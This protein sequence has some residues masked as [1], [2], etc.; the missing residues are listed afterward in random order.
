MSTTDAL[1]HIDA[2]IAALCFDE[3]VEIERF[4][5]R[6]IAVPTIERCISQDLERIDQVLV[7]KRSRPGL[8]GAIGQSVQ[9]A[10]VEIIAARRALT[11]PASKD[12]LG[13]SDGSDGA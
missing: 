6:E 3:A 5:G 13:D 4:T 2:A 10:F 11:R 7:P 9:Q 1:A 12:T 8:V